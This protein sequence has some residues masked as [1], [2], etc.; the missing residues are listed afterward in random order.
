MLIWPIL[1][2]MVYEIKSFPK[3]DTNKENCLIDFYFKN[4][5]LAKHPIKNTLV[6]YRNLYD[7]E[8]KVEFFSNIFDGL[9]IDRKYFNLMSI[10]R[11]TG[12]TFYPHIDA[13]RKLSLIY[14]L[15]GEAL[16]SFYQLH[17]SK[18]DLIQSFKMNLSTW[19]LFNNSMYHGV[20]DINFDRI[21][22][23]IDLTHQ[24]KTYIEA[25]NFFGEN[26]NS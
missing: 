21:S 11:I 18:L 13:H 2:N 12:K 4:K 3:L 9:N 25:L 14:T 22:L 26:T 10:Q 20:T 16:T 1:T 17:E 15:R 24:F 19:Y 8:N 5:Q 7:F 6:N 23:I